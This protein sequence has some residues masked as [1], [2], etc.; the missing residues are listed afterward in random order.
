MSDGR[1][2]LNSDADERG[3]ERL[4][5]ACFLAAGAAGV[6]LLGLYVAGGQTQLEGLL[7]TIC[8][9]GLGVGVILWAKDLTPT[10]EQT[11][12]A[13]PSRARPSHPWRPPGCRAESSCREASW[14]V[15]EGSP[16]PW[17]FRPCHSVRRPGP[18]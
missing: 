13:T 11:S 1:P 7:L 2:P 9:G 5:S 10:V 14:Q 16:P 15:S 8:L 6:L 12:P 17:R 3:I 4:A 18:A